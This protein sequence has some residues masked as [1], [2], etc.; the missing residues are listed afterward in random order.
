MML[1]LISKTKWFIDLKALFIW[2]PPLFL[3]LSLFLAHH[4]SFPILLDH[5]YQ[6]WNLLY[7][8]SIKNK[9]SFDPSWSCGYHLSLCCCST[10][11]LLYEILSVCALY[12][13]SFKP[14]PVK[15]SALSPIKTCSWRSPRWPPLLLNLAA[16][17]FQSNFCLS[18]ILTLILSKPSSQSWVVIYNYNPS[19]L[20]ETSEYHKMEASLSYITKSRS[21]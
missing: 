17:R 1:V 11:K 9:D 10:E 8:C 3:Q 18:S 13:L 20:E 5:S 4:D 14:T 21:S 7:Y 6:Q 12:H 16:S 2:F 19:T 15:L